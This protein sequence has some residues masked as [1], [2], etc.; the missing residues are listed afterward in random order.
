LKIISP[1]CWD[2]VQEEFQQTKDSWDALET[3]YNKIANLHFLDPAYGCGNFLPTSYVAL[4]E[5]ELVKKP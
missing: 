1:L 3:L 5:L 2:D 4:R